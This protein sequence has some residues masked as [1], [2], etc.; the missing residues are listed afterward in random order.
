MYRITNLSTNIVSVAGTTLRK[1]QSVV[2]DEL[3]AKTQR[4]VAQ[5]YLQAAEAGGLPVETLGI[6]KEATVVPVSS[7]AVLHEIAANTRALKITADGAPVT[8]K[9]GAFDVVATAND[10]YLLGD[11]YTVTRVGT[12]THISFYPVAG[13]VTVRIS[14]IG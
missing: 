11:D 2:V 12:H 3:D 10:H 4:M 13:E 14:E 8:F 9:L 1:G 6:Y 5:G 7:I